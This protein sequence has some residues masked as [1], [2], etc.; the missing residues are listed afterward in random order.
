MLD[1]T[2]I[3]TDPQYERRGAATL[4][5]L[6]GLKRCSDE[7]LPAYLESTLNAGPLYEKLG[8][9]NIRKVSIANESVTYEEGCYLFNPA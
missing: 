7:G 8:F 1:L 9:K 5:T 2:F 4:L 6:W 3:G